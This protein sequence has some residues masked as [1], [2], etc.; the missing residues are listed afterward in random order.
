MDFSAGDT[1]MLKSGGEVM[2][3]E[4]IADGQAWCVWHNGKKVER[5]SFP[6]IVLTKY[7]FSL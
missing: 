3:V 5:D 1:V 7:S 2:T 4:E 6:V